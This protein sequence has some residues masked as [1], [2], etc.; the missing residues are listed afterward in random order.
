MFDIIAAPVVDGETRPMVLKE[1]AKGFSVSQ[2]LFVGE[3]ISFE[4]LTMRITSVVHHWK[5]GS[6]MY[7]APMELS[8]DEVAVLHEIGFVD[9]ES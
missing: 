2:W 4:G 9:M 8:E 6:T 7:L 3:E 1:A 5:G